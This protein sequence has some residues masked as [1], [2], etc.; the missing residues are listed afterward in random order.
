MTR[1]VMVLVY[2]KD[3]ECA[4]NSARKVVHE[5]IG[6]RDAFNYYVDFAQNVSLRLIHKA[7]WGHV[8]SVLQVS[9]ARFP[10]DDKRGLKMVNSAMEKNRKPFK[11]DMANIRHQIEHYTDDELF[12]EVETDFRMYRANICGRFPALR[13]YLYDFQ[14]DTI[15]SPNSLQWMLND[16]DWNPYYIEHIGQQDPN[17][18]QHI[19]NQPLWVVPF[20]VRY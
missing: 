2:A 4:L 9:N 6:T 11:K 3:S 14:G 19:W 10:I 8:E 15:S 16:S 18:G 17:W 12:D 13:A 20:H 1:V 5:K 7:Q